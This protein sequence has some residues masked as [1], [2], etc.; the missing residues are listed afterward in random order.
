MSGLPRF[1]KSV[2]TVLVV[3]QF[4]AR[5]QL[6]AL[7]ESLVRNVH[8]VELTLDHGHVMRLMHESPPGFVVVD[9][10][11]VLANADLLEHAVSGRRPRTLIPG[12]PSHVQ[13]E[14]VPA[15]PATAM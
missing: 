3:G 12:S 2:R 1:D 9:A 6:L 11:V 14:L 10:D 15:L 7:A 4:P 8:E 13:E 5:P